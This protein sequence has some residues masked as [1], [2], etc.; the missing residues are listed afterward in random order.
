MSLRSPQPEPT[1]CPHQEVGVV[2]LPLS[3]A[4]C[5]LLPPTACLCLSVLWRKMDRVLGPSSSYPQYG[6]QVEARGV[7]GLHTGRARKA[8]LCVGLAHAALGRGALHWLLLPE[9]SQRTC[10]YHHL[11]SPTLFLSLAL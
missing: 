4:L 9:L 2:V 6:H 10:V 5:S 8:R 3:Q 7:W 11:V 1:L